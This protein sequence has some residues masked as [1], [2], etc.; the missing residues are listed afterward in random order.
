MPTGFALKDTLDCLKWASRKD[1]SALAIKDLCV[2]SL[3]YFG[4][5]AKELCTLLLL[6]ISNLMLNLFKDL[7]HIIRIGSTHFVHPNS[8]LIKLIQG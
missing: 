8:L 2:V 1:S 5:A 7:T 6:P 3:F 4:G